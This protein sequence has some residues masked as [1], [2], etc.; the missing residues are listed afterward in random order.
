MTSSPQRDPVADHLITP[1][2]AA[3]LLIDYQPTQVS[4]VRSIDQGLLV[5]N[6]VSTVKTAN[7]YAVP[8][9]HSTVNVTSGRS[10][11]TT[12]GP[13][14]RPARPPRRATERASTRGRTSTPSPPF[15]PRTGGS[16]SSAHSGRRSA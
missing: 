12:P 7:A 14:R 13:P 10:K 16:S 4:K 5:E 1:Q 8:I 6:I 9:V 3:L 11:P 2:N 15:A